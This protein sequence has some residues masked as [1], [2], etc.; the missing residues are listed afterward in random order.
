MFGGY[1]WFNQHQ[2]YPGWNISGLTGEYHHQ[3][4]EKN[5]TPMFD[6]RSE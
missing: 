3:T 5:D 6:G 1:D 2:L 4:E